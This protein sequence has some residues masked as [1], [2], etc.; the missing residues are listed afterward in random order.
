VEFDKDDNSDDWESQSED[1][2]GHSDTE[3]ID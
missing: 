3:V 1:E 2:N